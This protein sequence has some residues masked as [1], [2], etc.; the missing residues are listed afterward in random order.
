V[1]ERRVPN[2]SGLNIPNFLPDDVGFLRPAGR[3]MWATLLFVVL[4][5]AAFAVIRRPKRSAEPPTWAGAI[6][7]AIAVWLWMTLAYAVV[8]HEWLQFSASYLN[9]GKDT[10]ALRRNSIV[11]FDVSREAIAHIVV[12]G[13]YV[14][15]LALNVFLFAAWQKRTV[16]EPGEEPAEAAGG[17]L[18]RLRRRRAGVS[19]YGR[20]VT[21]T[22]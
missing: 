17:P 18:A 10:F 19:A 1:K 15:M 8:P 13:I 14:N 7:G 20:P 3:M 22:E 12:T 21:T 9:F 16:A 5:G 11:P 4:T 2:L 6:A